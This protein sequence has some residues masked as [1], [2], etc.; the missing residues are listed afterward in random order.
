MKA[1]AIK[2]WAQP[3][4]PPSSSSCWPPQP[5]S[6]PPFVSGAQPLPPPGNASPPPDDILFFLPES[7]LFILLPFLL[8]LS[9]AMFFCLCCHDFTIAFDI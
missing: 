8:N 7:P 5:S 4:P 3:Q 1:T 2:H 9:P 6:V